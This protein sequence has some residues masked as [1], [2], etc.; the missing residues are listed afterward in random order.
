MGVALQTL[1]GQSIGT[2]GI[3]CQVP[4]DGWQ[5]Q[6]SDLTE[7]LQPYA[8][9]QIQVKIVGLTD[10]YL[11]TTFDINALSLAAAP[12]SH[13]SPI[14]AVAA[15]HGDLSPTAPTTSPAV[16][17]HLMRRAAT[18]VSS[19]AGT[20]RPSRRP[21]PFR[22]MT[23][24]GPTE[25]MSNGGFESGST[26]WTFAGQASVGS[27]FVHSGSNAVTMCC[28][29]F[30]KSTVSIPN[31]AAISKGTLSLWYYINTHGSTLACSSNRLMILFAGTG[32]AQPCGDTSGW[33]QVTIDV[34]QAMMT[35]AGTT[36]TVQVT[37]LIAG[38]G[39]QKADVAIDDVSL[40]IYTSTISA[41]TP[42]TP[43]AGARPLIDNG[44]FNGTWA[45]Q[46]SG[47]GGIMPDSGAYSSGNDLQICSWSGC[48]G[49][50]QESFVV[51]NEYTTLMYTMEV[52]IATQRTGT[53][54]VDHMSVAVQL[55]GV[56][57]NGAD[58]APMFGYCNLDAASSGGGWV[59]QTYDLSSAL[60]AYKGQTIQLTF[61]SQATNQTYFTVD[62]VQL[63]ASS[64]TTTP[65]W[66]AST[67]TNSG[68]AGWWTLDSL[69]LSKA[70]GLQVNV[71]NGNLLA[72]VAGP[73]V[74]GVAGFDESIDLRYNSYARAAKTDVGY[75]WGMTT[76]RDVGLDLSVSNQATFH[77][78][79]GLLETFTKSGSTYTAP[80]GAD[81][82]LTTYGTGYR[83]TDNASGDTITFDA[84]GYLIGAATRGGATQSYGYNFAGTPLDIRNSEGQITTLANG[85]TGI[86]QITDPGRVWTYGY[87]GTSTDNLSSFQ[88]PGAGFTFGYDSNHDLTQITDPK[89]TV[90]TIRYVGSGSSPK[91]ASITRQTSSGYYTWTFT[92][93]AGSTIVTDPNHHTTTYAYDTTNRVT[94]VTD[95][96]THT[97]SITWTADNQV[98]TV[99]EPSGATTTNTY[100]S[101]NR[102]TQT[103]LPNG[104]TT[105]LGYTNASFPYSPTS[106]TDTQG[107]V[108]TT[109]YT[110][111][112]LPYYTTDPLNHHTTT[113]YDS[114]GN[115]TS[116]IDV[117]GHT[118]TYTYYPNGLLEEVTPPLNS[119][120]VQTTT[121]YN[122]DDLPWD[123]DDG[124]GT[125]TFTTYD[126]L[127]DVFTTSSNPENGGT[128]SHTYT[129]DGGFNVTQD[130]D[131]VPGTNTTTTT[132]S[133]N[134]LNQQT[135]QVL[136]D[137]TTTN[138]TYD[139]VGNRLA[140]GGIAYTYY[141]DDSLKSDSA[142]TY[143]Y[144]QDGNL[145]ATAYAN[146]VTENDTYDS[147]GQL[148]R[149]W[150]VNRSGTTLTSYKYTYTNPATGKY[151][152]LRYTET[153]LAGDVTTNTYD[154]ANHLV[155]A[156]QKNAAGAVLH[157]YTYSYNNDG[158]LASKTIDQIPTTI[159]RNA[160]DQVTAV[161][162]TAYS[163]DADGNR[164]S[165]GTNG[166]TYNAGVQL[167]GYGPVAKPSQN[168][169]TY[170]GAGM[171]QPSSSGATT[172]I[173]TDSDGIQS[174]NL[175]GVCSTTSNNI[176]GMLVSQSQCGTTLYPL[177]DGNG[178][179]TATTS[180]TGAVVGTSTY[181]P[182]GSTMGTSGTD[183][184][185]GFVGADSS[186]AP[187][188]LDIGGS[189]YDP[190]TASTVDATSNSSSALQ[191][192][193]VIEPPG[194]ATAL[195]DCSAK[196]FA[197]GESDFQTGEV[198]LDAYGA[199]QI[200]CNTDVVYLVIRVLIQTQSTSLDS[201]AWRRWEGPVT[202][203]WVNLAANTAESCG[204]YLSSARYVRPGLYR[205]VWVIQAWVMASQKVNAFSAREAYFAGGT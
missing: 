109:A 24:T 203:S 157:T 104:L 191:A 179:V 39:T 55:P 173:E 119:V 67:D 158:S 152:A 107:N 88:M 200:H 93:N 138:D 110:S 36:Q 56:S 14:A 103:Q 168:A 84:N 10:G 151:T 193:I 33:K 59:T 54:C 160:T 3:Q 148:T 38:G 35:Y 131:V 62:A 27:T 140:K 141:A 170:V 83:L 25:L 17:P 91:V 102:L 37:A 57:P 120:G 121:Q 12:V 166:Y 142:A 61:S 182:T 137:G 80:P 183:T 68:D 73:N 111:T 26:G 75:G 74:P 86:S 126:A 82:T 147:A 187:G 171:A 76:S 192:N 144:D 202:C 99:K 32:V 13:V 130:V 48:H 150:S 21:G 20:Q 175:G 41:A 22:A 199:N 113:Y 201:I 101:M 58:I 78:P 53:T 190:A 64:T 177:H 7:M 72:N 127:G 139:G 156:T 188:L 50:V 136:P 44:D 71:A 5:F 51:P 116:V 161:D 2:V 34:S 92:Y 52:K 112:G 123:T 162:G 69:D 8:G 124:N 143:T 159:T 45:W 145:T 195:L 128:T 4:T 85:T 169:V 114:F 108:A 176:S 132:Y 125:V 63:W 198:Y 90:T 46:G 185:A 178:S 97:T 100:D 70:V 98:A 167:V 172:P 204:S 133:F 205:V 197:V 95:A 180:A 94:A 79:S 29:A 118:T 19:H 117:N 49:N 106:S 42:Y 65:L 105:Q 1:D 146:G 163:N 122:A 47:T 155:G 77:D 115:P 9:Q 66:S 81:A 16:S 11:P 153:D 40:Q 89:G 184:T 87:D 149:I 174:E 181:S 129:Y 18:H 186:V 43:P 134:G 196:G 96:L 189:M 60:A 15:V 23:T 6:R 154:A 194:I 135:Q 164:T 30:V 165:D 28:N 31:T